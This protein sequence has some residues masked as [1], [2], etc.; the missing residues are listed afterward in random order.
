M[1]YG[2]PKKKLD[3]GGFKDSREFIEVLISGKF[4]KRL[5]TRANMIEGVFSDGGASVAEEYAAQWLDYPLEDEIIRPLA[6]VWPM[7]SATRKIPGFDGSDRSGGEYFGGFEMEFLAEEQTRTKQTAKLR[8]I[9]LKA[10]KGAIF[11]DV[12][13]E[14]MADG[15]GFESQLTMALRKSISRGMDNAFI[16]GNGAS[17]PQGILSSPSLISVTAESG[18]DS[19]TILYQ[20]ITKLYARMYPAGRRRAVF[21][22]SDT[23]IPQLLAL[24]VPVGTGG[25]AVPVLKEDSGRFSMLGRPVYFTEL[26]PVLGDANDIIFCDVSQY[27]IGIRKEMSIDVS[28]APG[29][30]Q[31]LTSLR[32]IVRFDGQGTWSK[33][34]TPKKGDTQSWVVGLTAR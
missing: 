8:M 26:M 29:W 9:E 28:N 10:R 25:S 23:T 3:R 17:E 2:D 22:A 32:I 13:N 19:D 15:L 14:L 5:S 21:I 11:T 33:P 12:S 27:G 20:N 34:I 16:N 18:Q 31:D 4:D 24:S 6:T 1:F 7:K 30:T